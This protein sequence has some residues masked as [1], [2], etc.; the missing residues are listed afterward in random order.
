[1]VTNMDRLPLVIGSIFLA[2][3]GGTIIGL[4]VGFIVGPIH[5]NNP[6]LPDF[7]EQN[8]DTI[9]HQAVESEIESGYV[10]EPEYENDYFDDF[11]TMILDYD[12][13]YDD[14]N[15][16]PMANHPL[17]GVWDV[18]NMV[19]IDPQYID[20]IGDRFEYFPD[21]TGF[22]H[23]FEEPFIRE[24][25]W[26]A[27]GGRLTIIPFDASFRIRTYDY[28]IEDNLFIIFLN[29]NRTSYVEALRI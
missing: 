29:R 6:I 1:M 26:E 24:I 7:L 18:I 5:L 20:E 27:E 4:V 28:E 10:Y 11:E 23:Y 13:D 14:N 9:S 21:G 19:D 25:M 3:L 8:D 2:L 16:L 12:F 22:E 15:Y 17:V